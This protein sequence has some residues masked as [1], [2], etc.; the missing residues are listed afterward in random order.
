MIIIRYNTIFGMLTMSNFENTYK[1]LLPAEKMFFRIMRPQQLDILNVFFENNPEIDLTQT[2][3]NGKT[4]WGHFINEFDNTTWGGIRQ[5]GYRS[6]DG[7]NFKESEQPEFYTQLAQKLIQS[8][9][10]PW[11]MNDVTDEKLVEAQRVMDERDRRFNT[12]ENP[13]YGTLAEHSRSIAWGVLFN[14]IK[15]NTFYQSLAGEIL[16]LPEAKPTLEK[17]FSLYK[18]HPISSSLMFGVNS[19]NQKYINLGLDV[20][21]PVIYRSASR[22]ESHLGSP[23]TSEPNSLLVLARNAEAVQQLMK[24][25]FNPNKIILGGEPIEIFSYWRRQVSSADIRNQMSTALSQFWENPDVPINS[26]Q[27]KIIKGTLDEFRSLL[28]SHGEDIFF[29][30]RAQKTKN[31]L[32]TLY[33]N[34]LALEYSGKK[35]SHG[36]AKILVEKLSEKFSE[37]APSGHTWLVHSLKSISGVYSN[38]YEKQ[39]AKTFE[40]L[41]RSFTESPEWRMLFAHALYAEGKATPQHIQPIAD[42]FD[43]LLDENEPANFMTERSNAS[44]ATGTL[45]WLSDSFAFA[46]STLEL[47]IPNTQQTLV[48]HIA[49]KYNKLAEN[50]QYVMYGGSGFFGS[51]IDRFLKPAHLKICQAIYDTEQRSFQPNQHTYYR[52][53][54]VS[55]LV[56]KKDEIHEKLKEI[57]SEVKTAI[58]TRLLDMQRT[59]S[60]NFYGIHFDKNNLTSEVGVIGALLMDKVKPA[61]GQE[62]LVEFSNQVGSQVKSFYETCMLMGR[63]QEITKK[64]TS[65]F[66]GAL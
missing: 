44:F 3:L 66:D 14:G 40:V 42:L 17:W 37:T 9:G 32:Y 63:T 34:F 27:Q 35:Q 59:Q 41:G 50:E 19:L 33:D 8:L 1:N 65:R 58:L 15:G 53:A 20:N 60:A 18:Q 30:A 13:I 39:K 57:D 46:P 21:D 51:A 24:A 10:N 26:L 56:N 36:Q 12:S 29:Q 55:N 61:F 16:A 6:M 28:A 22:Y 45:D 47:T 4:A 25:G 5:W 43:K 49:S 7:E 52:D 48:S 31:N 38:S 2:E 64:T 11:L 23:N 62:K 54:Q